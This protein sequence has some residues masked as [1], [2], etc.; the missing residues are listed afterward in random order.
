LKR[1]ASA[2]QAFISIDLSSAAFF[3]RWQ[4]F[5]SPLYNLISTVL[6]DRAIAAWSKALPN[7]A[8]TQ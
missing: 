8:Q 3:W 2:W 1:I 4:R 5:S 7:E 6:G